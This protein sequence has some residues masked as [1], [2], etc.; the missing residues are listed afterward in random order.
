MQRYDITKRLGNGTYGEVFMGK[1]KENGEVVAIKTMK[2][3]YASWKECLMLRELVSLRSL[4]CHENIVRMKE[5]IRESDSN[6]HFVFE[7][8][9][10]GNLYQL[11]EQILANRYN[12]SIDK[13]AQPSRSLE[14]T[15]D[16]I[17][18]IILQ[19][20]RGL[21]H[22]HSRGYIHRDIKP[23]NLLLSGNCCKIADFGLARK[24][25]ST[26]DSAALTQYISTR[27]YRAPEVLLKS[28]NYTSSI[29]TFAVGCVMAEMVQ[30]RPLLPGKSEID[31]I[32]K[33]FSLLGHP[34]QYNWPEGGH[35]FSKLKLRLKVTER[36]FSNPA[37]DVSLTNL[38]RVVPKANHVTLSFLHALLKLNPNER[39]S[40]K[41]SLSHAFF[42]S[43]RN[44]SNIANETLPPDFSHSVSNQ[45][46]S[47]QMN[48]FEKRTPYLETEVGRN[49]RKRQRTD[50]QYNASPPHY[51]VT[52]QD[53]NVLQELN[54]PSNFLDVTEASNNFPETYAQHCVRN[55]YTMPFSDRIF[56]QSGFS[57]RT[58]NPGASSDQLQR[59]NG[60]LPN[61][62]SFSNNSYKLYYQKNSDHMGDRAAKNA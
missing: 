33:S 28:T 11:M 37:V 8:M 50:Y 27:W 43:A 48:G 15:P 5:V 53:N 54:L 12:R 26:P 49:V 59:S 39:I 34:T 56:N 21:D 58:N 57:V 9:P 61:P 16:R 42:Y 40:A 62:F 60:Y 2:R 20:M 52:T 18:S 55:Q 1:N 41:E 14:I 23:E 6:L 19:V 17:Q 45:C 47:Q 3:K 32:Y 38:M 10:D 13:R 31:Q 51:Q 44:I 36:Q 30:L 35:L 29:D 22:I 7:Y 46:N 25:Q 4:P 24:P